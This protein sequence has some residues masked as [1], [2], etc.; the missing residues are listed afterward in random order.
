V[1]P[2]DFEG[3]IT[4]RG[5]MIDPRLQLGTRRVDRGEVQGTFARK[6]KGMREFSLGPSA[7]ADTVFE[8]SA[9]LVA[10]GFI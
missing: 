2:K 3:G 6:S 5:A 4:D 1:P 7:A 9:F 10:T 8:W